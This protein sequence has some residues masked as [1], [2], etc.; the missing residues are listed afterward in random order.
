M[1][2]H[3]RRSSIWMS[4]ESVAA[5]GTNDAKTGVFEDTNEFLALEPGKA[6]HIE[7]CCTPTSSSERL[8]LSSLSRHT[9]TASRIRFMSVS[10]VFA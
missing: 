10:R 7:I 3:D 5:F 4:Q 6:S 9:S 8:A 2:G 1:N